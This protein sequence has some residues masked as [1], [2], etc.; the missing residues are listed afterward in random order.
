MTKLDSKNIPPQPDEIADPQVVEK[1]ETKAK[2]SYRSF[3]LDY[4]WSIVQQ[5]QACTKPGE[6]GALLRREGLY[7]SHL[8]KW[9]AYFKAAGKDKMEPIKRGPKPVEKQDDTLQKELARLKKQNAALQVRLQQAELIIDVQK[10]VAA[11]LGSPILPQP[12]DED[13]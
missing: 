1:P 10:K 12:G 6:I 13:I 9:R 5:A 11:L 4:K 8:S 2:T 3:T 7:S